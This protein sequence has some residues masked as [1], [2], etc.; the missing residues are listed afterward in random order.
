MV[1][2]MSLPVPVLSVIKCSDFVFN[3]YIGLNVAQ[4]LAS[5]ISLLN[6]GCITWSFISIFTVCY[7][8][9]HHCLVAEQLQLQV[10]DEGHAVELETKLTCKTA[11]IDLLY[12]V[13]VCACAVINV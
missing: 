2:L 1:I 10:C 9:D 7:F 4:K 3:N 11:A 8:T 13:Y 6:I 12:T 5:F